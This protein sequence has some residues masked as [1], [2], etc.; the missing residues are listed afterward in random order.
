[1]LK[2]L[3][4]IKARVK[5]KT[6]SLEIAGVSRS[7]EVGVINIMSVSEFISKTFVLFQLNE[8]KLG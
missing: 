1:M 8:S 7:F 6:I 2:R 4:R 5:R 3:K